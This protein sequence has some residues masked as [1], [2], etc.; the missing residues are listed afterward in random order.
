MSWC[1][2]RDGG[3]VIAGA[4]GTG[5]TLMHNAELDVIVEGSLIWLLGADVMCDF[6]G[7]V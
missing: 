1:E 4:H 2:C 6:A 5:G 7:G 3:S